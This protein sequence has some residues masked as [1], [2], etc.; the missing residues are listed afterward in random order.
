MTDELTNDLKW[1]ALNYRTAGTLEAEE[2]WQELLACVN[3]KVEA[4]EAFPSMSKS[5]RLIAYLAAE[6][7]HELGYVWNIGLESWML[8]R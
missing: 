1:H 5:N 3:R 4:A 6:K 8:A 7:L 2:M